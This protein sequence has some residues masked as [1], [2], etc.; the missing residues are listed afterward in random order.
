MFTSGLRAGYC[1]IYTEEHTRFL[2]HIYTRKNKGLKGMS[3]ECTLIDA[4]TAS[5]WM[6][7]Q[8]RYYD[9]N[10]LMFYCFNGPFSC[11]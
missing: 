7:L 4:G 5:K 8:S 2:L 3:N 11:K 9:L 10:C 6:S 1:L